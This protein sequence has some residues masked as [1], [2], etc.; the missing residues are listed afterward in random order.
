MN[1]WIYKSFRPVQPRDL[2]HDSH[3]F[4]PYGR[5]A[6]PWF[7]KNPQGCRYSTGHSYFST[8]GQFSRLH[9]QNWVVAA[10]PDGTPRLLIEVENFKTAT[11]C[12]YGNKQH[13]TK[14]FD[15]YHTELH[16]WLVR[17]SSVF[18]RYT[19]FSYLSFYFALW[20]VETVHI[21]SPSKITTEAVKQRPV[22][23][24]ICECEF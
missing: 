17:Y 13:T 5:Y 15:L 1:R 20:L 22:Y 14:V 10:P 7:E 6:W 11:R 18:S 23:P 12:H 16:S 4:H 3:R 21:Q 24:Y 2:Y 8:Y 9:L 19:I